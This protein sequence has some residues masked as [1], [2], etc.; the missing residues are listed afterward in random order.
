MIRYNISNKEIKQLKQF[1][2]IAKDSFDVFYV[3]CEGVAFAPRDTYKKHNRY[4]MV[5]DKTGNT[6]FLF[7]VLQLN[8]SSLL[9]L[10]HKLIAKTTGKLGAV[11]YLTV[12]HNNLYLELSEIKDKDRNGIESFIE[13]VNVDGEQ[14]IRVQLGTIVPFSDKLKEVFKSSYP[15]HQDIQWLSKQTIEKIIDKDLVVLS[16]NGKTLVTGKPIYP[17]INSD[18]QVGI[19]FIDYPENTELFIANIIILKE[20]IYSYHKYIGINM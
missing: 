11:K 14:L 10:D 6:D 8:A 1:D 2:K 5:I 15:I 20:Q 13:E 12:I 4:S 7:Q 18:S 3:T 19:S 9:L 17:G 16:D